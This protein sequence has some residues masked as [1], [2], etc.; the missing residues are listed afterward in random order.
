MRIVFILLMVSTLFLA[1]EPEAI[2]SL[3]PEGACWKISNR[4]SWSHEHDGGR[5]EFPV[6]I[7]MDGEYP[8]S[9]MYL[10]AHITGDGLDTTITSSYTFVDPLGNWLVEQEGSL[11]KVAHP[12]FKKIELHSGSYTISLQHN[13]RPERVCGVHDIR[14][15]QKTPK[16]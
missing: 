8:F 5:L 13:M 2:V 6:I 16:P 7:S 10:K 11:Y 15:V 14:V 12:L 3:E 4:L 9:N 1:C